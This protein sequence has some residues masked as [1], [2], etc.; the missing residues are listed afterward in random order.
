MMIEMQKAVLQHPA[1]TQTWFGAHIV[2]KGLEPSWLHEYPFLP[3]PPAVRPDIVVNNKQKQ[4][5]LRLLPL[6]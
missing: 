1:T 6:L 5:F 2:T 4:Q 3:P